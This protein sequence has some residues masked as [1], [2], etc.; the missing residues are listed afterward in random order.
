[1]KTLKILIPVDFSPSFNFAQ[2]M[3][4]VIQ[5]TRPTE[6]F[7]LHVIPA[8]GNLEDL[9]DTEAYL[10]Q[11]TEAANSAFVSL[12]PS[13]TFKSFVKVGPVVQTINN[14]AGETGADLVVMGTKGADGLLEFISGSEAQHVAR[15]SAVPVMTVQGAYLPGKLQHVLVVSD[16]Q[17]PTQHPPLDLIKTLAAPDAT[18]HLLH[19]LQPRELNQ[20]AEI[21]A[22]MQEFASLNGLNNVELH[23]HQENKVDEGVY[24]F[25]QDHQM[26]LVCMGTHARKGLSH[27]FYGS[28]AERLINHCSK[29][30]LTYHL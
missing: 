23:L 25:N 22:H 14:F 7:M 3:V 16:F 28:I 21:K 8:T 17:N 11:S 19:I 18:M 10:R 26:D 20:V 13:F 29:P 5:N 9:E 15:Y 4:N 1:M 24:H 30:V 12:Q 27:L 2:A 6:V